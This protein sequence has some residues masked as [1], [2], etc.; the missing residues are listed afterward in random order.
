MTGK[1]DEGLNLLE[2]TLPE[3]RE[4][5][6]RLVLARAL[7]QLGRFAM[8]KGDLPA[9]TRYLEEGL[10]LT[11]ELG[12]EP[13]LMFILRQVGNLV[14]RDRGKAQL[15]LEESLAIA[16]RIG[17]RPGES[18]AMNSLGNMWVFS[19]DPSK[20]LA[21]YERAEQLAREAGARDL[22]SIAT[23]N[24]G[25]CLVQMGELD[26]AEATLRGALR[27]SE[28]LDDDH[29][30]ANANENLGW[31]YVRMIRDE[32]ARAHL[33][34]SL[35][36]Y[37]AIGT[38]PPWLLIL[39]AT[40]EARSGRRERALEWVGLARSHASANEAQVQ[41]YS[42]VVFPEIQGDL[43]EAEVQAAFERGA[44]LDLDLVLD[45]LLGERAASGKTP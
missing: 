22:E 33:G 29:Q 34:R 6:S 8:W 16:Q 4:A 1:L 20:G 43:P 39:W 7:G 44:R 9:A 45:E 23:G 28:E 27:L 42:D 12:D 15:L 18:S 5:K 31:L 30:L 40:L 13:A 32:A 24:I 21:C 25:A 10:P 38:K 11:R 3:I 37:R 35:S 41:F 14:T 19:G 17:D 2:T 26:R 36:H